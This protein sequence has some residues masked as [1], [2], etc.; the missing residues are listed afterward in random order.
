MNYTL[1]QLR[2]FLALAS[3]GSFTKAAAKL[4]VSQP[5]MTV[6][7]R[8][9][10]AAFGAKLFDREPRGVALTRVG[11]DLAP[12]LR[13]LLGEIEAALGEAVESAEGRRGT[14]RIAALP[15]FASG[16][17]PQAIA[18]FRKSHA[19]IDFVI[20]D[21]VANKVV[22]AVRSGS[23]DLGLTSGVAL[24]D[25]LEVLHE[26]SDRL[27]AVVPARHPLAR[28]RRVAI[29]DLSEYPLVLM[30]PE[31]SVR[32]IVDAAFV[33]AGRAIRPAAEAT[34]MMTA[35]GLV[36]AGLGVTILP[37][38]AKEIQAEPSLRMLPIADPRFVRRISLV[39]R[40]NRSLPRAAE[41]FVPELLA[42]M[43]PP[44]R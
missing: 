30:E 44:K 27:C 3:E 34:Y 37:E 23:V 2:A 4:N 1:A 17:L 25:D 35:V 7:I 42:A 21:A 9:L 14:I 6:Q 18:R 11:A 16:R 19:A 33:S 39:K 20:R 10:E 12:T 32:A 24:T 31:T 22:A 8:N 28:K 29:E 43:T 5:A 38:S 36:R 40:I 41:E 15:S 13:R 26:A